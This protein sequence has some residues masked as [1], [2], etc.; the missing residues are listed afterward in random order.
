MNRRQDGFTIIEVLIAVV[1]LS[2]GVLALASSAGGITRMM[3]S[4]QRKTRSF[5][6][7]STVIETLRQATR[8]SAGCTAVPASGSRS[9]NEIS[10]TWTFSNPGAINNTHVVEVRLSYPV[11]PRIKGDTVFATLFC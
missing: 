5:A 11:G 1:M 9:Q 3:S 6:L 2:I 7:A 8:T 4:G 10:A